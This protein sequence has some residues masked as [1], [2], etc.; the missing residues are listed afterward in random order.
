MEPTA[1]RPWIAVGAEIADVLANV[2]PNSVAAATTFLD[3]RPGRWFFTGQGRSGR[4]AAMRFMHLGRTTHVVGEATAPSIRPGDHLITL[5][6]S[7]STAVTL[8]LAR[9]AVHNRADLLAVSTRPDSEL[10][11]LATATLFVPVVASS[12]FGGSLFEQTA[13]ILLDSIVLHLAAHDPD[14]YRSM[15]ARHANL[16]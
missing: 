3:E 1:T 7:G 13:L 2:D 8:H 16:E 9:L 15:A 11:G 5:S 6:S 4:M 10:A 14:S 12:Q